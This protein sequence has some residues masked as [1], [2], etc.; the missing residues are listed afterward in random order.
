MQVKKAVL[1]AALYLVG[2]FAVFVVVF[3]IFAQAH[4]G[5]GPDRLWEFRRQV[6]ESKFVQP[7][8][9][10]IVSNQPN[11]V[12]RF[13]RAYQK[14]PLFEE[15]PELRL[16]VARYCASHGQSEVA[17]EATWDLINPKPSYRRTLRTSAEGMA[18]WLETGK[19]ESLEERR[20]QLQGWQQI[21]EPD[22]ELVLEASDPHS[23]A[24]VEWKAGA[25]LAEKNFTADAIHHFENAVKLQP[26]C[27]RYWSDLA[28]ACETWGDHGMATKA[29]K[30]AADLVSTYETD[31]YNADTDSDP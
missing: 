27:K 28:E 24:H 4:I 21:A 5:G 20:A 26:K 23:I 30:H 14:S 22:V 3:P 25:E 8:E 10:A 15:Y 1:K 9:G 12:V 7:I 19:S 31:A 13:W 17:H 11:E 2:A 18:I 6:R 16:E 29:R